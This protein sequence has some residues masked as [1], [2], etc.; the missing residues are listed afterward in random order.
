[1]PTT[2]RQEQCPLLLLQSV[3]VPGAVTYFYKEKFKSMQS[4]E[5]IHFMVKSWKLIETKP[6]VLKVRSVN[7]LK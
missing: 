2:H 7:W 5:V 6:G 4:L 1:M 3:I